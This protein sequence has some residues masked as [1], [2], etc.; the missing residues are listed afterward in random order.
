MAVTVDHLVISNTSSSL[1]Y[2]SYIPS[3]RSFFEGI[4][5]LAERR[6]RPGDIVLLDEDTKRYLV[7][8][9]ARLWND[10][11]DKNRSTIERCADCSL[12]FGKKQYRLDTFY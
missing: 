4:V 10:F 1:F 11:L 2:L 12:F 8:S 9:L 6:V 5:L 7:Q 3:V